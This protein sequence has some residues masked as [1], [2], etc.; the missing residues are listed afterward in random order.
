MAYD[1]SDPRAALAAPV[2]SA[3]PP[4]T[5][6]AGAEYAK[7]YETKPQEDDQNGKTWYARGQNFVIVY[8]EAKPGATFARKGQVDEYVV[9]LHDAETNAEITAGSEK[10]SVGGYTVNFVPPGDSS[11]TLPK[12][13]SAS[14]A[15]SRRA[16]P[17]SRQSAPTPQAMPSRIRTFR[18]TS[19]G[20]CRRTATRSA[21]T[22][23]IIPPSRAGSAAFSAAPPSW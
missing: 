19:P 8:T 21:A 3:V 18:P 10:K 2:K 5:E 16:R 1:A 13:G 15:C 7:F 20:R 17:T 11:L 9:L 14:C 23:S 22:A 4:P 12:G 6:F